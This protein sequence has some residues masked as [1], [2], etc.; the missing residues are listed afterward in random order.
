MW[1]QLVALPEGIRPR[2]G[3]IRLTRKLVAEMLRAPQDYARGQLQTSSLPAASALCD[4]L[5][6]AVAHQV[7]LRI[8][9][10]AVVHE[11]TQS[12]IEWCARAAVDGIT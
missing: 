11:Q 4:V 12:Q 9:L 1:S 8:T 3:G 6:G 5:T 7:E 2:H 10:P